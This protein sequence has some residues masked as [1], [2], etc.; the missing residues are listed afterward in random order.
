MEYHD[1]RSEREY[2]DDCAFE[3]VEAKRCFEPAPLVRWHRPADPEWLE[4]SEYCGKAP[5]FG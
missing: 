3:R 1:V 5:S 2:V 4:G